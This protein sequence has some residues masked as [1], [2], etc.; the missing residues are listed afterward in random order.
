MP[1][2][3]FI[4][5]RREDTAGYAGRLYDR[6]KAAFP[7]HV[8]IDVGEIPPGADFV[9]AIEKHIEGCAA[10]ITLIGRNWTAHK[11]L[12]EPNDFVRLEVS[13]ALQR[14]I[15]VIPVLVGAGKLPAAAMLPEDLQPLLRRHA[16]SITDE[17]W[18]HD[19]ERLVEALEM[20]LGPARKRPK[21]ARRWGVALA[22]AIVLVLA[23][24]L[25]RQA[26]RSGQPPAG[27]AP[28]AANMPET[29]R[30]AADYDKS[31][32]RGYDNAAK[33]MDDLANKIGGA[34]STS[35]P[36][37][38]SISP[39]G[40][41]PGTKVTITGRNFGAMNVVEEEMTVKFGSTS[42][43]IMAGDERSGDERSITVMVPFIKPGVV[44]VV[45]SV[46][47]MGSAPAA[48]TITNR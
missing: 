45:I 46:K 40:G 42:A 18:D 22:I 8:F 28:T 13:G 26:T 10:L 31:V 3:V 38:T 37:I 4:S 35:A 32:A 19:C 23:L 21:T 29:T 39:N 5:Y 44:A 7:G 11:R 1:G 34:G 15:T 6:L 43:P 17:D 24:F 36:T 33:V 41:P 14:D 30:A 9:K 27:P 48:F 20:V 16:I 47:G 2:N 25:L 12:Q